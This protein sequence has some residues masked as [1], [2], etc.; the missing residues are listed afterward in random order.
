MHLHLEIGSFMR[1]CSQKIPHSYFDTHLQAYSSKYCPGS[2]RSSIT[3]MKSDWIFY[4]ASYWLVSDD[5]SSWPSST[6]G[7]DSQSGCDSYSVTSLILFSSVISSMPAS[8]S[9]SAPYTSSGISSLILFSRESSELSSV[10]FSLSYSSSPRVV[11]SSQSSASPC[12]K[13]S[14]TPFSIAS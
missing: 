13:S 3:S 11:W 12:W 8:L 10:P 7:S 5:N 14:S 6:S 4:E 9:A 2:Q 1:G